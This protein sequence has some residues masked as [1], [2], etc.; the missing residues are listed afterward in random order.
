MDGE[1]D[2]IVKEGILKLFMVSSSNFKVTVPEMFYLNF[3]SLLTIDYISYN[4][5]VFFG[6]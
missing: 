1:K 3:Q 4:I 5:L 6:R 2:R